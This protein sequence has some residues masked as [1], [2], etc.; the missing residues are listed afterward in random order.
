MRADRLIA[1]LM[2]LQTRESLTAREVSV[3]L[4]ISERT[5]RRDLEALAMSG[6]PVYS[7]AGR[8]GG[9]RL[10][11]GARTDLTGLSSFEARSLFLALGPSLHGDPELQAALR[12]LVTALPES[13]RT[14]ASA[15]AAAIKVD[16]N[17][18]GQIADYTP[19]FLDELTKAVIDRYQADIEYTGNTSATQTRRVHP[20]GLVTKRSVWYLVA[21]TSEGMRTFRLSRITSFK[22]ASEAV[23]E[24]DGFD[25]NDHWA[26]IVSDYSANVRTGTFQCEALVAPGM[27]RAVRYVFRSRCNQTGTEKDGRIRL[28]LAEYGL[29]PLAANIAGFG[30]SLELIEPSPAL[31]AELARI[32]GE[33]T[34]MYV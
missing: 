23:V 4:E 29:R 17:G 13:F 21:N 33:L 24:P 30:S 15:A 5:A 16:P 20:L 7:Q 32:A 28:E 12:K 11:G 9:W 26:N 31:V 8:G 2:L 19:P 27:L 10:L 25:L 34:S 18:W 14:E 6:V 3:E 22:P 1:L